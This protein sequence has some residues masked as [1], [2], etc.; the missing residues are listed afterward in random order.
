MYY[1]PKC[2]WQERSA[3]KDWAMSQVTPVSIN[4]DKKSLSPWLGRKREFPAIMLFL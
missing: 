1:N 2:A 4:Y 3:L